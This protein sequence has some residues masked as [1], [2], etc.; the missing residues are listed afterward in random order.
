MY[1]AAELLRRLYE[2]YSTW[3]KKRYWEKRQFENLRVMLNGDARWLAAD[4]VAAA[5]TDRYQRAVAEDW[6]KLPQED[7]SKLRTR[8]GLDPDYK[9]RK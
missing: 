5:L 9:G 6:Y 8:L 7:V 4:P 1:S 2:R 3:R